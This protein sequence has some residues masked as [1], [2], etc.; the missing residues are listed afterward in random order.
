LLNVDIAQDTVAQVVNSHLV[1]DHSHPTIRQPGFDLPRSGKP[2]TPFGQEMTFIFLNPVLVPQGI[3]KLTLR[4]YYVKQIN[5][6]ISEK[7]HCTQTSRKL[8]LSISKE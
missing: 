1:C 7:H 3:A 5:R 8:C 6:C 4:P 2:F